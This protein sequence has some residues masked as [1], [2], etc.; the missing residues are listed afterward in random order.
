[1]RV[2]KQ[3]NERLKTS[4]AKQ[5]TD[6]VP[7]GQQSALIAQ[8]KFIIDWVK[9]SRPELLQDVNF[10][11]IQAIRDLGLVQTLVERLIICLDIAEREERKSNGWTGK[12]QEQKMRHIDVAN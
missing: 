3:E 4:I 2:L 11:E 6:A 10:N 1:M 5:E 7:P 9:S 12:A 8:A